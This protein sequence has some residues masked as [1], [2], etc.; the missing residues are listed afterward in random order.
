MRRREFIAQAGGWAVVPLITFGSGSLLIGCGSGGN[1][2]SGDYSDKG[3]PEHLASELFPLADPAY[4][5]HAAHFDRYE[6]Y[7]SLLRKGVLSNEGK[8]RH[9]VLTKLTLS[10]SFFE[11][12]GFY[13]LEYELQ[14]Y[15]LAILLN[16][17]SGIEA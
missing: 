17:E 10:D 16:P 2:D 3:L 7:Q 8:V 1:G 14:L 12:D 9:E 13:Y 5:E 15:A 11:F 4:S 6:L